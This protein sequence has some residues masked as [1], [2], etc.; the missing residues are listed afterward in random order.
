MIQ[1]FLPNNV[2]VFQDDSPHVHLAG[3]VQ[4][5]FEEHEG[6]LQ[7]FPWPAQSSNLKIIEPLWSVLE[8]RMRNRIPP[9]T[10]LKQLEQV[11][12]EEWNKILLEALENLN[13]SISRRIA[14][15]LKEKYSPTPY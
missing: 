3:T 7:H 15:V 10:S 5:W 8:A 1:M 2:A 9:S 6:K 13:E 11:L 4:S 14:V 12:L